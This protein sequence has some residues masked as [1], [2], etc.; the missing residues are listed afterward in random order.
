MSLQ[1]KQ[2]DNVG[3][4]PQEIFNLVVYHARHSRTRLLNLCLAASCF[5]QEAQRLLYHEIRI[6]NDSC[7]PTTWRTFTI[8]ISRASQLFSTLTQHNPALAKHVR[9]LYHSIFLRDNDRGYRSLLNQSIALMNNIEEL[10]L[11][12]SI[13]DE[14]FPACTSLRLRTFGCNRACD[15]LN[16]RTRILDF[17][18]TQ[19]DLKSL[20]IVWNCDEPFPNT[21][22]RNLTSLAG[23]R[24]AVEQVLPGRECTITNL[25]WAPMRMED[26]SIPRIDRINPGLSNIRIFTL[27]GFLHRPSLAGFAPYLRCL[28]VLHLVGTALDVHLS[29][30]N[31]LL[32]ISHNLLTTIHLFRLIFWM[33]SITCPVFQTSAS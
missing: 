19:P 17:L 12:H 13:P 30:V 33:N 3:H 27:G 6:K 8:G 5:R 25:T 9:I 4:I 16:F 21:H 20:F 23:D 2:L 22:C 32:N 28:Q 31:F 29:R 24:N 18:A 11:C 1:P 15:S 14:I 26:V 7:P 10:T